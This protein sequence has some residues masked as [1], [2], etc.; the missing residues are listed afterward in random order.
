M[1]ELA[2]GAVLFA[3]LVWWWVVLEYRA[4]RRRVELQRLLVQIATDMRRFSAA[5]GIA[6]VPAIRKGIE[7]MN[8]FA[9]EMDKLRETVRAG[10]EDPAPPN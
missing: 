5:L 1:T 7:A 9:R 6:L 3:G 8:D 10:S 4:Y 2:I